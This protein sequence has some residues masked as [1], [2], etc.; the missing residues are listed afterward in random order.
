MNIQI[1][2]GA[3]AATWIVR[4]ASWLIYRYHCSTDL[5]STCFARDHGRAYSGAL[6]TLFETVLARL[7]GAEEKGP[8]RSK[9]QTRWTQG[10]WLGR[11]EDSDANIVYHDGKV[12]EF[13]TIRRVAASDPRRWEPETIQ[14]LTVTPWKL[15]DRDVLAEAAVAKQEQHLAKT[16]SSSTPSSVEQAK[17]IIPLR[18]RPLTPGCSACAR[19]GHFGHGFR[20]SV[21]CQRRKQA[22]LQTQIGPPVVEAPLEVA[23]PDGARTPAADQQER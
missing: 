14:S 17:K 23:A 16:V 3:K 19:Q 8:G 18:A 20:H 21:E 13:R 5:K 9:W 10:V 7:P 1:A 4:H 12:S 2:S 22:W 11:T 15:E 6:V